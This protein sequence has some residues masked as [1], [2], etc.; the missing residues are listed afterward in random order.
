MQHVV[1]RGAQQ[2]G[3]AVTA[4][5][6]DHDQITAMLFGEAV[7][8]LA[9]LAV[10]ELAVVFGQLRVNVDQAIK[11]FLGLIKLLLLQLRQVHWNIAAKCHGHRLNDVDQ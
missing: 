9:R 3:Q 2:Q 1:G 10:G 11:S 4:V 8:F 7:D 5:A 6:A